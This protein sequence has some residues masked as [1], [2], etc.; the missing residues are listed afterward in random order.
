M[1]N[2]ALGPSDTI[3]NCWASLSSL[4]E[5]K[6]HSRRPTPSYGIIYAWWASVCNISDV[7]IFE[8]YSQR[9]PPKCSKTLSAQGFPGLATW[10]PDCLERLWL[11]SHYLH[12]LIHH[13]ETVGYKASSSKQGR[14][15]TDYP[16]LFATLSRPDNRQDRCCPE[17]RGCVR[18]PPSW[19]PSHLSA[20]PCSTAEGQVET[21]LPQVLAF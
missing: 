8:D 16:W 1:S 2:R 17:R 4:K 6:H 3:V 10:K 7:W 12:P 15:G 19:P 21:F 11:I 20:L 9:T 18:S 5:S 13:H 14:E